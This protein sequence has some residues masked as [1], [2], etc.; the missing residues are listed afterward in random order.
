MKRLLNYLKTKKGSHAIE[1]VIITPIWIFV[2][3]FCGYVQS[4]S[5]ARQVLADETNAFA[6]I[7]AISHSKEEAK[8][9]VADYII[10]CNLEKRF[11]VTKNGIDKIITITTTTDEWNKGDIVNINVTI[12][13]AFTG[14][15]FNNVNIGGITYNFFK[16]S[17]T[18]SCSIIL[19]EGEV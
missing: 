6:N 9:N 11:P 15:N 17:F 1:V 8:L 10:N 7:V 3:L 12:D 5:K 13:T 14:I 19:L 4:L 16:T 2:I 18:N